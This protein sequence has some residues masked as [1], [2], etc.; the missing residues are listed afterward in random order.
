MKS[1]IFSLQSLMDTNGVSLADRGQVA[2]TAAAQALAY[3]L[4]LPTTPVDNPYSYYV[5]RY[6]AEVLDV[7]DEINE[8]FVIRINDAAELAKRLWV[9]RYSMV[10]DAENP[11]LRQ[12]LDTIVASG[13]DRHLPPTHVA[14]ISKYPTVMR[15]CASLIREAIGAVAQEG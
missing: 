13:H 3:H 5:E 4:P 10:F 9:F 11:V 7:L 14:L 12:L 8:R 6:N 1:F 15:S 2:Y